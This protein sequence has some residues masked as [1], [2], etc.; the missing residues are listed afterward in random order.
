[1]AKKAVRKSKGSTRKKW[2]L[3]RKILVAFAVLIV[4]SATVSFIYFYGKVFK[5][6]LHLKGTKSGYVYIKT[7]D[8]FDDVVNQ[9]IEKELLDNTA[10][11]IWMAEFLDY[12]GSI[13]SG[14]F[15]VADRMSNKDLVSLLK[16]GR[17]EPIRLTIQGLRTKE[18]LAGKVGRI[19]EA[20]SAS[21]IRILTESDTLKNYG[22]T[23]S[24]A[25]SLFIPDTYEFFWDTPADQFISKI[26]KAYRNFWNADRKARAAQIQLSPA[27][28]SILASI[29]QQE[30]NK[31]DEWPVI[32]GVYMNRLSRGMKLQA[33]PTVKFAV[34]DFAL[35][36]IRGNHL[37]VESPYNTYKYEGLPPG[38]IYM[39]SKRCMD[40]VLNFQKHNYL[41]F[42]A[43]ADNSGYH[44]FAVN[45]EQHL[46]NARQYQRNLNKRGI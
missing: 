33:D 24:T 2:G 6:N 19:L 41:Y 30:S 17:Q 7:T 29:V 35:R 15:K 12:P 23:E 5:P 16:S 42:C 8:T 46:Q 11:F 27:R 13:K 28:V 45:F 14:R 40:A 21:L 22:L 18:Q 38:P 20:D 26:G 1:M 3:M 25:L 37:L 44:S 39:A 4:V 32:A 9:L 31:P 36:R 43:R 10:S 34:G